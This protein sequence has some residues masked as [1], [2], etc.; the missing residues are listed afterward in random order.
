MC[1]LCCGNMLCVVCELCGVQLRPAVGVLLCCG[2]MLCVV[3]E[4]C[5]VQ[6]RP[7]VGVLVVLYSARR[8]E[9]LSV[10]NCKIARNKMCSLRMIV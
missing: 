1:L 4:L 7:A 8:S 2:S 3:C 5:A 6:L 10:L 9:L